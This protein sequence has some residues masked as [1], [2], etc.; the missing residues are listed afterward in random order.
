MQF[1]R[2]IFNCKIKYK[3]VKIACVHK[4]ILTVQIWTFSNISPA[5]TKCNAA[6]C[7]RPIQRCLN[8]KVTQAITSFR[9]ATTA[10]RRLIVSIFEH[11]R[12]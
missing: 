12:A 7:P 11:R 5:V 2:Q 10:T 3:N 6:N 4:I 9:S 1:Q 8:A